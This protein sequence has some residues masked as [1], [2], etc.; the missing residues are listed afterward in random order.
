MKIETRDERRETRERERE[1]IRRR[2]GSLLC[3]SYSL[4]HG[5]AR[6]PTAKQGTIG[7]ISKAKAVSTH[8]LTRTETEPLLVHANN[9]RSTGSPP[10]LHSL[11]ERQFIILTANSTSAHVACLGHGNLVRG[12]MPDRVVSY[13]LT[14]LFPVQSSLAD[15][16]ADAIMGQALCSTLCPCT[17]TIS[18]MYPPNVPVRCILPPP[19]DDDSVR[20]RR[21]RREKV[22]IRIRVRLVLPCDNHFPITALLSYLPCRRRWTAIASCTCNV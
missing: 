5:E 18:Q 15:C 1:K 10:L 22:G 17:L 3:T 12:Y 19:A 4:P 13:S 7:Q 20:S 6:I 14:G 21:C 11:V 2:T 8:S 16:D 9:T